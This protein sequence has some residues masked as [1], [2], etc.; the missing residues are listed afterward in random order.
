MRPKYKQDSKP[1]KAY[2]L[3][4]LAQKGFHWRR[5]NFLQ[6]TYTHR[7]QNTR[8]SS[9]KQHENNEES[10]VFRRVGHWKNYRLL[11]V[12]INLLDHVFR[13]QSTNTSESQYNSRLRLINEHLT[14]SNNPIH[15]TLMVS[16]NDKPVSR[17]LLWKGR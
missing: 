15:T 10:P 13:E 14:E 17:S 12:L 7:K 2:H 8:Y 11:A 3:V 4:P 1:N 5:Y 16:S 6:S 9:A